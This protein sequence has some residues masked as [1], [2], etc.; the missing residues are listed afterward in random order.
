[1]K[2]QIMLEKAG[3]GELTAADQLEIKEAKKLAR[4][5]RTKK[6]RRKSPR[7]T[8]KHSADSYGP[9]MIADEDSE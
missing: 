5:G 3:K 6:G 4:G 2:M 9:S 1:M 8:R 7:R